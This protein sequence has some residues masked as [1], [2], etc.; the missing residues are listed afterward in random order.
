MAGVVVPL[1]PGVHSAMGLLMSDVRHDYIRSRIVALD[2]ITPDELRA[3]FGELESQAIRDLRDEGFSSA[4]IALE[5]SIDLRYAGQGYELTIPC[6]AT[7]GRDSIARLRE[8]FDE[9]H[10]RQFG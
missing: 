6:G 5:R 1:Y 10:R 9:T 2:R 8:Q 4:R 7:L 3:G